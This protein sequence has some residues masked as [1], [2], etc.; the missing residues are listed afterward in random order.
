MEEDNEDTS[1]GP[2]GGDKSRRL[3]KHWMDQLYAVK[4]NSQHKRWVE[5]G[6]KIVKRYRDERN[7]T[8]EEGQRRYNSLWMNVEI[9]RPALYGK[10]PLPV[11]ERRFND[12]DPVG[13]GAAQILERAL[14][15]EIEICGYHEAFNQAV[16]DYLLPGR[17]V[18]WV[19]YEP[20]I[21][22]SVSIPSEPQVDMRDAEGSIRERDTSDHSE[23][24]GDL[25]GEDFSPKGRKRI[26]LNEDD[27]PEDVD[28]SEEKLMS[29]GDRILR[30][31]TPVDFINWSDFFTFP[32][33]A[34][35]WREVTTVCKRIF[36]SREQLKKRFGEEIGK[37][38]PLQKDKRGD[39]TQNTTLM[40]ADQDKAQVYEIWDKPTETVYWIAEG[41]DYLCDMEDDP[42]ELENFFPCPPPLYANSTTDSLIPVPDF[43]Q[44]QDQAIQIDE[45]SQRIAMLAKAC[46]VAGVYNAQAKDIQRLLNES[47]ENELIPVDAWAAF[48]EGG[49]VEGNISLLPLKEI[50]GVINELMMVKKEQIE[51]MDRLTGINDIM[52]G[53]SDARET[54]GGVRIKSN[55]TG[56]RL[57][58][59]QNEVA[60][61]ARDTLRIMADIMCK[62]F[63]PQ[64]LIEVSGALYEEGLGPDDMPNMSQMQQLGQQKP[65]AQLPP[66]S[67]Q[68]QAPPPGPMGAQ[69][70]P[71]T[72]GNVVP[73]RGPIPPTAPP[74]GQ[75]GP[76]GQQQPSMGQP[77]PGGPPPQG[78]PPPGA[79][80]QPGGMPGQPPLPPELMQKFEALQRIAKA[81]KL[82][83]DEKIRGFRV[84]IEVDSTIYGDQAQDKKD[85]TDFVT[86]V[87]QYLQQAAMLA[88][89]IP[90]ILPL[91]GKML[92]FA[93]RGHRIGRDLELAIEEFTDQAEGLV[94]QKQQ[95][96]SQN[97]PEQQ[98]MQLEA[99]KAQA[100]L[101]VAQIKA[102]SEEARS[103]AE[104]QSHQLQSQMEQ[105]Q[106]AAETQSKGLENQGETLKA[107]TAQQEAVSEQ[108]L[109]QLKM[110]IEYMKLEIEMAKLKAMKE[111]TAQTG[112][113]SQAEGQVAQHGTMQE[114]ERTKQ[115]ALTGHYQTQTADVTGRHATKQAD[116]AGH[117][118][119]EQAK[120]TPAPQPQQPAQQQQQP[121]RPQPKKGSQSQ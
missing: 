70:P 78:A 120:H 115:A 55:N 104:I 23:D 93:A 67:G 95:Q 77:P 27:E 80:P 41:Y 105:Q 74:Q 15:N 110:N 56:T 43:L 73:I 91:M 26:P 98:K 1:V 109:S 82:L 76:L 46:K 44:Y 50:I 39:R 2:K 81:I 86:A 69:P 12:K 99:Q 113:Q 63:S 51:E 40:P 79:P 3:A 116:V 25:D 16:D 28:S 20:K 29:T 17:G 19:R 65:P 5:R 62:H 21:Q 72:G 96:A 57:T 9:L 64:S 94:K 4:D 53:T 58:N 60:R 24:E 54:L 68:Q 59:R 47:V 106:A 52:R 89:Q 49:G 8:D 71:A 14:R 75:Q 61:F 103:A 7:R 22:E 119:V 88:M 117:H 42:L 111:T 121:A 37:G 100:Q 35:I 33:R 11:A 114:Q 85:R 107:Q 34:R 18:V 36:M 32:V 87:T 112:M 90:E 118:A 31:S 45:L 6:E 48:A 101:Q 13:R 102:K 38:I 66:P 92:Q 83:R 108:Q 10:I 84:D 97:N 30:E